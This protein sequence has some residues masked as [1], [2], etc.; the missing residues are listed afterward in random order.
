MSAIHETGGLQHFLDA[1][2]ASLLSI[3][4]ELDELMMPLPKGQKR[5]NDHQIM[6]DIVV[7]LTL[8]MWSVAFTASKHGTTDLI[9]YDSL[10]VSVR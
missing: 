9:S 7:R 1:T 2:L 5:N 8:V 10:Q 4:D 3:M 6:F